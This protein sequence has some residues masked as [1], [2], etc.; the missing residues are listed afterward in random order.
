MRIART[1]SGLVLMGTLV[2]LA[3][4]GGAKGAAQSGDPP[5]LLAASDVAAVIRTDL[6]AGI[7]VSGTLKPESDV[8]ITAAF[9]EVVETVRVREGQAVAKGEVL[10]R[11]RA[12]ARGAAAASAAAALKVAE[13]D[14]ERQQNL[15]KEGAVS[16]RDVDGAEAAYRAAQA[17]AADATRRF[18]DVTVR[19]PIAGVI[20]T[21]S[22]QSGDRVASG[23]PMFE[24]VDTAELEFE[25]TVPSEY[26]EAVQVGASVNL[27]VNGSSGRDVAGKVARVNAAA[28]PATRQ[29][30]VYVRVA[31]PSRRLVSGLFAS[32]TIVTKRARQTVAVPSAAVH[33]DGAASYV[34]VVAAGKLERRVVRI[35][36]RDDGRDLVEVISGLAPGDTAVVGPIEGLTPGQPVQI[37]GRAS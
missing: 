21:R 2:A 25:A 31:N 3:G 36:V 30:K 18:D 19:A 12:G 37:A 35:G 7:P 16:Q 33:A 22:V 9:D 10:A 29:V 8:N 17:N 14:W 15:F 13:A 4:C 26:L 27:T 28:D 5:A 34:L 20:A 24:L 32:G 6:T 23:D 1:I 11:F